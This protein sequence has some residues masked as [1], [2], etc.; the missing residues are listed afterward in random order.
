M[1]TKMKK[2]LITIVLSLI[3]TSTC[4]PS[5]PVNYD[6]ITSDAKIKSALEVLENSYSSGT[7]DILQGNNL[8]KKRMKVMFYS[9]AVL[10][11][12]YSDVH[13][14]VASDKYGTRYILINTKNKVAPK[15][16][17]AALI[18]HEATHQ[19]NKATEEEELRAWTNEVKV[20]MELKAF[21]PKIAVTNCELVSRL[22]HLE[23]LYHDA[24]NT[25]SLIGYSIKTNPY[26]RNLKLN[27]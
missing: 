7:I 23:N 3:L 22:N 18:A 21:N 27:D 5:L 12:L 9:L 2:T 14:L 20:W 26:Y 11:P 1:C 8:S 19:L 13:A 10:S 25:N 6:E 16:A 17:L 4:Q 24:D 15:E